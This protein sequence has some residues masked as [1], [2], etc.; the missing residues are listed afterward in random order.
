MKRIL[1]ILIG[2]AVIIIILGASGALYLIDETQQ[3]VITQ[4][5]QPIGKPITNAGLHFKM[6]FIHQATYFDKWILE[7][8][9]EPNQIP[10]KDKRYIL[11]DSTA[12]WKIKDALKFLQSVGNEIGG[13]A[14]LD[15]IID[16]A[17]RDAVTNHHLVEAVRNTNRIMEQKSEGTEDDSMGQVE[18]LEKIDYGREV[19]TRAILE[20]ASKIVPQYGIELIDV[21]IKRINYVADVQ[22]KVFERMIS[23]RKRAAEQYLSEGEGK[24]AEIEGKRA[25]ELNQIQSEAYRVAEEIKGKADAE[26]T[27]IYADAYNKAPEFYAFL[28]TL[29]TYKN[30]IDKTTTLMLTTDSEYFKYLKN[31]G[32]NLE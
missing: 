32:E 13:Q 4:F 9:G 10:T 23:E 29:E 26:A 17:T 14:R 25:K 18:E 3:V 1:F 21:R 16:S 12:R 7:W 24:K 19:L 6:P 15:D 30:T 5:G 28:K 11:V 2:I 20:E 22:E 8:D 27:N 31:A